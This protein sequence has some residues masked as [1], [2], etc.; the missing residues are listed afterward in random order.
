[1]K[2][3]AAAK[4]RVAKLEQAIAAKLNRELAALPAKHGFDNVE[5]FCAAVK[6][7][8]GKR[9]G[10]APKKAK[11]GGKKRKDRAVITDETRNQVKK[12]TEAGKT[13]AEIAKAAGISSASVQ[14]IKKKLGLVGKK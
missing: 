10:P 12:L 14:N 5:A 3:L 6:A 2:K 4:A 11:A 1:M 9:R 13:G 8:G 7:A